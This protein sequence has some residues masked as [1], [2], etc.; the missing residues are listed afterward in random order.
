MVDVGTNTNDLADVLPQLINELI[1]LDLQL[2]TM[3][4]LLY[5]TYHQN[6]FKKVMAELNHRFIYTLPWTNY[7]DVPY[8]ERFYKS[9][10][11]VNLIMDDFTIRQVDFIFDMY[12][13]DMHHLDVFYFLNLFDVNRYY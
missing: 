12:C 5:Q 9:H 2:N 7:Q 13:K 4:G 1:N 10:C 11:F 3:R 6:K 8:K